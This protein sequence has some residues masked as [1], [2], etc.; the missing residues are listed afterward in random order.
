M[1]ARGGWSTWAISGIALLA[2]CSSEAPPLPQLVVV[3]DTDAP[4]V[5]QLLGDPSFSADAHVDTVRVDAIDATGQAFDL[6]DF[7]APDAKDWPISF[8]IAAPAS[9]ARIRLR[10]RGFR[11]KLATPGRLHDTA[12]L[13]PP[14]EITLD[15]LVDIE[16]PTE[17]V[18]RVR[19]VLA[20]ACRGAPVS[21]LAPASNCIDAARTTAPATEGVEELGGALPTST[22]VGSW[23]G[24][25][26]VPCKSAKVAGRVCVPGGF[27]I[28]GDLDVAGIADQGQLDSV[29]LRPVLL[30]PFWLDEK[31]VTV[32]QIVALASKLTNP[33]PALND[34]KD[35]NQNA[36]CTWLGPMDS[37]NAE[38]PINCVSWETAAEACT[39]MNGKLPTEAQWEHAARGRGEARRYPW[40]DAENACCVS[41]QARQGPPSIP[42]ECNGSG[43]EPVGSHQ[44]SASCGGL[45]DVSRDEVLDMGGSVT[46]ALLD[47][48]RPYS[49]A[50]WSAR[51]VP[52]DPI[53][54]SAGT[55]V[56]SE[57]G[58]S[59]NS[60]LSTAL[61]ARRDYYDPKGNPT[62]GFRCAYKDTP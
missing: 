29:P 38:L 25:R 50:C 45:G 55:S 47:S 39:L 33:L 11:G 9:A 19:V 12:T 60:G 13:D 5:S 16:S 48:S 56:H 42:A 53:C 18:R 26:E 20:S 10:I 28:L 17:G 30:S 58:G 49:D 59:W 44:A 36:F 43:L 15:R 7:V 14:P 51:G 31:E 3:V 27:S 34:P 57:R 24:A 22:L 40:G 35:V 2:A 4:T 61:S 52:T 23:P 8:G 46:E 32:A 41:S 6:R 37:P 1:R 21:F 62:A 54:I